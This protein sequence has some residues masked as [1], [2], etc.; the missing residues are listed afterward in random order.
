MQTVMWKMETT[1]TYY[2][3][4]P[5]HT[6]LIILSKA[7]IYCGSV[8]D[9]SAIIPANESPNKYTDPYVANMDKTNK[10]KQQQKT[11]S[12]NV[13][14]Y[15]PL[16]RSVN[17]N[18]PFNAVMRPKSVLLIKSHDQFKIPLWTQEDEPYTLSHGVQHMRN[19]FALQYP[20]V[21]H[22]KDTHIL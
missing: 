5:N 18:N 3:T 14:H 16:T 11:A 1:C 13:D 10:N 15:L 22:I 17:K 8:L 2:I 21:C 6:R 12:N 9:Q 7:I 20:S 4:F 19:I